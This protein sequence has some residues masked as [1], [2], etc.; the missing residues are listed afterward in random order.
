MKAHLLIWA[1]EVN[2]RAITDQVFLIYGMRKYKVRYYHVVQ[3]TRAVLGCMFFDRY[4]Y[5]K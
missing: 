5:I 1:E 4:I 3:N 2:M